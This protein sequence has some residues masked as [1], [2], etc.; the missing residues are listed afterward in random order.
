MAP[1]AA[2]SAR[3]VLAIMVSRVVEKEMLENLSDVES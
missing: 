1:A 3:S 2:A